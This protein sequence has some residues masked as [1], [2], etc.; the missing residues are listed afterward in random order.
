MMKRIS[1]DGKKIVVKV[2][3]AHVLKTSYGYALILDQNHVVFLKNWQVSQNWYGNEV[4]LNKEFWNV[5]EWGDF[6][7]DFFEEPENYDFETW[8][9]T[10]KE[11]EEAETT[12]M[13]AK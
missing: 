9:K 5:K 10:A 12:V 8:A 4:L 11:Q 1:E 7:V 2:A 3:D 6:S 13:W